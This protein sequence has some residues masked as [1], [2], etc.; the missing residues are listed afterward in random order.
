MHLAP[1]RKAVVAALGVAVTLALVIP[2]DL[3]PER[4]RPLVGV[5]LGLGTIA[6]VYRVRNDQPVATIQQPFRNHE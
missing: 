6:G 3:L 1:I 2:E 4:W 5:V